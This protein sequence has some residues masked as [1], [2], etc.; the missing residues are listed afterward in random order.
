MSALTDPCLPGSWSDYEAYAGLFT[1]LA[2]LAMQLI[3]F[4]AHY[5]LHK[6]PIQE[7]TEANG[8]T[9]LQSVVVPVE[10]VCDQP[11]H[12]HGISLLDDGRSRSI[13][14]YLLELGVVIHSVLI[15]ITLGTEE[16]S[17]FTAL[18]I[19]LCFH[20]FFEAVALG[21]QLAKLK[22]GSKLKAVLLMIFFA[23]TT[24][25]GIAIGIA[26][27]LN[28]YNPKSESALI[29]SGV[30]NSVSSGILIYVSLVDMIAV[31]MGAGAKSFFELKTGLKVLYFIALYL[32][33]ALM[34]VLGRWA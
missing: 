30:L 16:A 13:I 5:Q 31:E 34:A 1:M 14:T 7:K 18:F 20:Q 32:G 9:N 2:I 6:R 27:H 19:A 8:G 26:I 3:E 21:A 28:T 4:I 12:S 25:I 24:P 11:G 22:G 17:T 15:G 10:V 23:I 33:A 29:S